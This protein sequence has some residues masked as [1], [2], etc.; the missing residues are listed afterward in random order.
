M[1]LHFLIFG[2]LPSDSQACTSH[3]TGPTA[4][5]CRHSMWEFQKQILV[6]SLL[7]RL[8]RETAEVHETPLLFARVALTVEQMASL[9]STKHKTTQG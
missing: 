8:V 4:K 3:E 6:L 5:T 9:V 1:L 7:R 2:C